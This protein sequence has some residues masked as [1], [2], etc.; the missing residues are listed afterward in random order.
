MGIKVK[1]QQLE[2]KFSKKVGIKV[3][4]AFQKEMENKKIK[5]IKLEK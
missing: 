3:R 5:R 2:L 1:M 4:K